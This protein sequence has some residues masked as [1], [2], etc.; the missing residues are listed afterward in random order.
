MG[1]CPAGVLS[2]RVLSELRA[3]CSRSFAGWAGRRRVTNQVIDVIFQPGPLHF[4]FL[5]FLVGRE[6][7][8]LFDAI[9]RVVE[10]MI[11]IEHFSE[12]IVG[13]LEAPDSFAMFRKLPEDRMM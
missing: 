4:E 1:H 3:N 2:R 6:I 9:D 12:M 11:F 10:A 7:D 13:P 8:F 5:S